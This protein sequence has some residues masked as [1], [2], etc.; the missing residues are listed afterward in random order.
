MAE[1]TPLEEGAWP[2]GFAEHELAQQRRLARLP[3]WV[4]LKKLEEMCRMLRHLRGQA[5]ARRQAP[6]PPPDAS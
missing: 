2:R 6:P 5:A 4:R 1:E 3:L